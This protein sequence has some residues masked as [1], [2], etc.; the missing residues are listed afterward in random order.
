MT[1]VDGVSRNLKME[2]SLKISIFSGYTLLQV[3]CFVS[4]SN[5]IICKSIYEIRLKYLAEN[6][7]KSMA[8][9]KYGHLPLNFH[10]LH[11]RFICWA[12]YSIL[13]S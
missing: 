13:K 10:E 2:S 4:L 8:N 12:P 5:C 3:S 7:K 1:T 6:F 11:I 9:E